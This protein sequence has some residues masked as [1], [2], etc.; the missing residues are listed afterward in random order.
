[1]NG[2]VFVLLFF[3]SLSLLKR[4]GALTSALRVIER[5]KPNIAGAEW[6]RNCILFSLAL[7]GRAVCRNLKKS[8]IKD[9][10]SQKHS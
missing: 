9:N 2:G 5:T 7:V 6:Q 8:E 10:N 1:M 3:S 4:E